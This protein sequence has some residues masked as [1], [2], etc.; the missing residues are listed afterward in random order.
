MENFITVFVIILVA[1]YYLI[2]ALSIE[3]Y[4][5]TKIALI[6]TCIPIVGLL[7]WLIYKLTDCLALIYKAAFRVLKELNDFYK[8]LD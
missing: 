7:V 1:Q 5:K 2:I 6:V 8:N 4:I 3:G